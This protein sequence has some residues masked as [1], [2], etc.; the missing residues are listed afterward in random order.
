MSTRLRDLL[1]KEVPRWKKRLAK[2]G[3]K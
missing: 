1:E 2:C 3:M